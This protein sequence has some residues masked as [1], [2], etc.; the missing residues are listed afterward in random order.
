[1]D[2][3]PLALRSTRDALSRAGY[4]PIVTGD[5]EEALRLA[6]D[7]KPRLILLDLMLPGTDGITLMESIFAFA[8][9]PVIFLSGYG[10]EEVMAKALDAGARDYSVKPFSPTE[11]AARIRAAL[12]R[13]EAAAPTVPYRRGALMMDFADRGV[14]LGGRPMRLTAKEYRT[15]AELAADSGRVVTY[16]HLL[17]QV[18]GADAGG[19]VRPMRTVIRSLRRKLEDDADNPTYIFTEHSVGYWMPRGEG[20]E[21]EG[22]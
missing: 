6:A 5:P 21:P 3:D 2:D 4:A 20:T 11:L 19:E 15:L 8:E 14:T 13:R 10:Q 7:E 9:V 17:R 22:S 16:E 12:W 18:W 1:M